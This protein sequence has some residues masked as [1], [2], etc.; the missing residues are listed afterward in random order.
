MSNTT[1]PT[2]IA[3]PT[4]LATP[5]RSLNIRCAGHKTKIGASDI[6]VEATPTGAFWTET[7]DNQTPRK[8][9]TVE[10]ATIAVTALRSLHA[11]RIVR[12]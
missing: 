7:S 4:R 10:P 3:V 5:M 8:G 9:P 2:A 6:N 1:P 12:N 11:F